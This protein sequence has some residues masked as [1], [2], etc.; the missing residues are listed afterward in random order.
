MI[1]GEEMLEHH[2]VQS[3]SAWPQGVPFTELLIQVATLAGAS[4]CGGYANKD[5]V[6][7]VHN[8]HC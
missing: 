4:R 5:R 8:P 2:V 1:R 3:L 7:T 6:G